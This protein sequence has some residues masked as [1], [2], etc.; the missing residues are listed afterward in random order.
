M[1]ILGFVGI[2]FGIMLYI[3]FKFFIDSNKQKKIME[4]HDFYRFIVKRAYLQMKDKEKDDQIYEEMERRKKY[5]EI[6][7]N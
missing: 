7:F 5:D 1:I 2:L 3:V 4:S 6:R